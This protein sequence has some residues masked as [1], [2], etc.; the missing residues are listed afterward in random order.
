[1]TKEEYLEELAIINEAK[2]LLQGKQLEVEGKYITSNRKFFIGDKVKVTKSSG[3]IEVGY[4]S[5]VVLYM[6]DI[7]Y[8]CN[9]A[10]KDGTESQYKLYIWGSSKIE[11]WQD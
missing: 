11:K 3:V 9:K 4:I 1:M 6:G 8:E 2:A 10:R 7:A 5:K